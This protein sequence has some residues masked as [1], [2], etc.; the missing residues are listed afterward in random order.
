MCVCTRLCLKTRLCLLVCL[1]QAVFED[2]LVIHE[3]V[4]IST[5][6]QSQIINIAPL[7]FKMAQNLDLRK[8]ARSKTRHESS[9]KKFKP[10]LICRQRGL[11]LLYTGFVGNVGWNGR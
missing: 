11:E 4:Q 10:H 1:H 5:A 8:G 9:I 3:G 6:S 7:F 2:T